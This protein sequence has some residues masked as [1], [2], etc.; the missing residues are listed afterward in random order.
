MKGII[1][2]GGLGTR[3]FPTTSCYTKQLINIYD[4]PMIYYPLSTL[5]LMG[6]R[7]ILIISD[8]NSL[9]LYKILFGNGQH[10]GI[11]ISYRIQEE[12]NGIG[13]A[14]ILGKDFIN[15]DST[16][17]ILG[18]NLFYGDYDYF[19]NAIKQHDISTIF[20]YYVN[21]PEN[22]GVVEFRDN[23]AISIEEKPENP[24][25][26]Y[27]IPG[28]YIY[29]SSIISVALSTPYSN[30]GELEITDINKT[31]LKYGTL[32]VCSLPRGIAW[33][34]TGTPQGLLEAS[35]FIHTLEMRQ[36]LK[37][38]CIEEIAF[39]NGWININQLNEITQELPKCQYK[40]YIENI[41]ERK[42]VN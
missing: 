8:K 24:K 39:N 12:P 15:N 19:R 11:N 1:L 7:D 32:K 2:A 20:S 17:L 38:G 26:N 21:D 42:N 31:Y 5:M 40:N 16:V 22:Y 25:S 18:D 33:L 9:Y 14:F 30:R 35:N 13:E 3:F 27:A 29:D 34:D 4:K 28:L 10:L 23:R 6:I 36:G 37:I 41:I